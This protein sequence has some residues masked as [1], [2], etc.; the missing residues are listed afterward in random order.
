MSRPRM[1]IAAAVIAAAITPAM[2][3]TKGSSP[4]T[5]GRNDDPLWTKACQKNQAG[6][7]VCYVE[8]FV[9]AQPQN[10]VM[11][12]VQIGFTGD[13]GR[14]RLVLITPLGVWLPAGVTL[15]LDGNE[16][17]ALPFNTCDASACIAAINLDPDVLNRFA[18]GTTLTVRYNQ[19]SANPI[20]IPVRMA[21]LSAALKTVSGS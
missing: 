12:H 6:E 3:A 21:K 8:Q 17:V 20:D 7:D 15:I 2:A 10:V 13:K 11:L 18:G 4:T 5:A 9:I 1:I 16:P 19:G 14:P